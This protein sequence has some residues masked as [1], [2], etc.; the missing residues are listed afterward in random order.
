LS[1]FAVGRVAR[2]AEVGEQA[3]DA[4]DDALVAVDFAFPADMDASAVIGSPKWG[5]TCGTG[6]ARSPTQ[7][8]GGPAEVDVKA[9]SG[10]CKVRRRHSGLHFQGLAIYPMDF[11]DFAR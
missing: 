5:A 11:I 3:A 1:G 10:T 6:T 8:A 7:A 4:L 9:V 2:F